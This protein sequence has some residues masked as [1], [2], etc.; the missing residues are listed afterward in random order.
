MFYPVNLDLGDTSR[1]QQGV[2]VLNPAES[3]R[4]I[5][6]AV[7]GLAEVRH[8][9][10]D[11]RL[12][13]TNGTTNSFVLEEITGEKVPAY[14]FSIGMV[15]D[16]LLTMSVKDDR[17]GSKFLH[18]GE[19]VEMEARD[20]FKTLERG[21]VVIKGGNAVDPEGNAGVI[22]GNETGG[23]IGAL[24]GIA[25]VRGIP[26]IMPVGLEKLVPS[27][28]DA[29]AGWGQLTL[30]YAMGMSCWLTPVTTGLVVTEIQALGILAGVRGRLVAAGGVGGSEG[31]V[32][33]LLEGYE[34]N[35]DKAIEVVKAV[36]GEP[37]TEVPRHHL[38]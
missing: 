4:L 34:E 23:T 25:C 29:A 35:L 15:A 10:T 12:A 2:L 14:Q 16:G 1:V 26:L 31:A 19:P 24:L 37:K 38:S 3:K 6:R 8:A 28:R 27:V 7:A 30:N 5:A 32:I 11:A 36:K 9:Y 22:V 21:D 13:I 20:F 17:V 18:K 33:L